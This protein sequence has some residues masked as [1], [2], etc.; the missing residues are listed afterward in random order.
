[1]N[2]P[3]V[4]CTVLLSHKIEALSVNKGPGAESLKYT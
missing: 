4:S 2:L 1:M 3:I